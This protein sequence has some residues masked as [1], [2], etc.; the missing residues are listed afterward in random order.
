MAKRNTVTHLAVLQTLFP[1]SGVS[2]LCVR[3]QQVSLLKGQSGL[4]DSWNG[5]EERGGG[6]GDRNK[7]VTVWREWNTIE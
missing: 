4:V 1:F 2:T 5:M 6:G 3:E 7:T